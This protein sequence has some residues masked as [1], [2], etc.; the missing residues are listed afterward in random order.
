[1]I[2]KIADFFSRITNGITLDYV[3]YG[4]AGLTA[5][6]F[7]IMLCI[8]GYASGFRRAAQK[9]VAYL[10]SNTGTD[11]ID[12]EMEKFPKPVRN[13]WKN[14]RASGGSVAAH[15]TQGV[16]L[17]GPVTAGCGRN[18][19]GNF[20]LGAVIIAAAA[21]FLNVLAIGGAAIGADALITPLAVLIL[22]AIF[23]L[24]LSCVQRSKYKRAQA[25][26]CDLAACLTAY[27]PAQ[28]NGPVLALPVGA[29]VHPETLD[30]TQEN[31]AAPEQS[32]FYGADVSENKP[33]AESKAEPAAGGG[34]VPPV[35]TPLGPD[36]PNTVPAYAARS[37]PEKEDVVAQIERITAA[38]ASKQTMLEVA[39]LLQAERAKAEN[40]APEQQ[41]RL[42]SALATLLK[43]ISA[44]NRQ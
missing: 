38:G 11:R 12:A 5:L 36:F 20:F 41:K 17:D 10:K 2:Q 13:A 40:K 21:F 29:T 4:A 33:G 22:G 18:A 6:V 24:I 7:I 9:T 37:E 15:L 23:A 25:A 31:R 26:Y 43:A 14:Y 35:Y 32:L 30:N 3:F 27:M 19:A 16:C 34:F 1:M 42:N 8:P 39:K 44:S 28:D